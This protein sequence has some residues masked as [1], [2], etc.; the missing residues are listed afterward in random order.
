MFARS[1]TTLYSFSN[2]DDM[3]LKKLPER[4]GILSNEFYS[5]FR[6]NYDEYLDYL[7]E[8]PPIQL[9]YMPHDPKL[10]VGK[11]HASSL[12][13]CPLASAA[14]RISRPKWDFSTKHLM[15]QGKRDAAPIQEAQYWRGHSVEVSVEKE[16]LRGRLDVLF[17][18][19][20]AVELKRRDGNFYKKM[21]PQPKLTD[22]YQIIAY[23]WIAPY[24]DVHLCTFTRFDLFF[25]ELKEIG[26]GFVLLDEE[27]NEWKSSFNRPSYL[28]YAVVMALTKENLQYQ[29]GERTDDPMPNFL[30]TSDG[31]E[32]FHWENEERPK[33]YKTA[34]QGELERFANIVPHCPVW[35]HGQKQDLI[36]IEEVS[37]GSKTYEVR[38]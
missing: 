13:R 27:G 38:S 8:N 11:V 20:Y 17:G 26:G 3:L 21:P 29:T 24:L 25:W 32:C 10:S 4:G 37:Y 31:V 15:E 19:K 18:N 9:P 30:N 16:T 6:Q 23:K 22:V 14:S 5:E 2:T 36:S 1:V 28:N 12:G 35:C 33:K 34:Y 7:Q